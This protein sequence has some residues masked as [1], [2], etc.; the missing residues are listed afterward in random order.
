MSLLAEI[1]AGAIDN[2]SAIAPLLLKLRL[3]AARL[4]S[5]PLE[6]WIKYESE[7]Y[8][9]D[10]EVPDYRILGVTYRASFA[11]AFGS[12]V[13]NSQVP[14]HIIREFAGED[15]LEFRVRSSISAIDDL[16]SKKQEKGRLQV[17]NAAN[18]ILLLQG[19]M[20]PDYNCVDV[21]GEISFSEMVAVSH[22][23]RSRIL[24][25]TIEIEK[26]VPS[27][28]DIAISKKGYDMSDDSSKKVDKISQQ[29][30]Y[31]SY[32]QIT[33][34]GHGAKITVSNVSGDVTSLIDTLVKGGIGQDDAVEL[35]EI[36]K[37]ELPVSG[38]KMGANAENWL[39]KNLG[40]AV[41]GTWKIGAS[42]AAELIALAVAKFYG[43][44]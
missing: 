37:A 18:L 13:N 12:G 43:I 2:N 22:A 27:A 44:L 9:N 28:A 31:G 39:A 11:G 29:V 23:V 35:A 30:I 24:E 42:A 41:D 5:K 26:E 4:D 16:I 8:P 6:A 19:K 14:S 40:K 20:Y 32:T 38:S 36:V 10:V 21:V 17:T 3:L 7:G 25:L 1:Q 33:N 34:S 15:W